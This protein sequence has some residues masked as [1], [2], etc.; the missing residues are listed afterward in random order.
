MS[1]QDRGHDRHVRERAPSTRRPSCLGEAARTARSPRNTAA[2][3]NGDE[4][5]D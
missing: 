4:H 1:T 5:V 2:P 3:L